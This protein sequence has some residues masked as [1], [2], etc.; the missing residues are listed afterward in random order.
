[1]TAGHEL[2]PVI[3]LKMTIYVLSIAS[4]IYTKHCCI[5]DRWGHPCPHLKV[6]TQAQG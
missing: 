4:A 2:S 1:M 5:G 3:G 6:Q